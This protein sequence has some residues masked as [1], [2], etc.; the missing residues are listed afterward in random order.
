MFEDKLTAFFS[1]A[2]YLV[3]FAAGI[4]SFLAPC[5]LAIVPSYVSY[6]S[7]LSINK[8]KHSETLSAKEHIHLIVTAFIF[9]FGFSTI[10]I[11]LGI[12]GDLA[13][14]RLMRSQW[15]RVIGGVIIV[16]FA[17]YFA[18]IIKIPLFSWSFQTNFGS[19]I[20]FLSPYILGVS[21]ALGWTACTGPIL[22][23]IITMS[24]QEG[25]RGGATALMSIFSLGLGLPFLLI[26]FFASWALS[27]LNKIKPY[28]RVIEVI[29]AII[30]GAIGVSYIYDGIRVL[31]L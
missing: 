19:K 26:A 15:A 17:L 6:I 22:G 30:L 10:F 27:A 3:S 12:F 7:G 31:T 23:A 29:G 25:G 28:F 14:A 24:F 8:L 13:F 2:P 1:A 18:R 11:A 16:I 20:A 21:F 9:I 4:L 5:V